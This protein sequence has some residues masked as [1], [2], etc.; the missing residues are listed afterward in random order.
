[1]MESIFNVTDT[2]EKHMNIEILIKIN[3]I[4]ELLFE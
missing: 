1:M 3:L 2:F 4:N